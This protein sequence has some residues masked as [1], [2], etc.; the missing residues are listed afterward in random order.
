[1]AQDYDLEQA[2]NEKLGLPN[3]KKP[4]TEPIPIWWKGKW[5][6]RFL[7]KLKDFEN[8]EERKRE[9]KHLKAY[10][11]GHKTYQFG[12]KEIP[13]PNGMLQRVP[14]MF[15]VQQELIKIK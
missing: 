11:K 8:D 1:M 12:Y 13:L 4:K 10:I 5:E 15:D 7:G 2:W 9:N 6:R 14:N 3:S